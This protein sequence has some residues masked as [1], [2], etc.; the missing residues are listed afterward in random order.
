MA[1]VPDPEVVARVKLKWSDWV[2]IEMLSARWVD[3]NTG[4]VKRQKPRKA[5]D[6]TPPDPEN[7]GRYILADPHR[8][9]VRIITIGRSM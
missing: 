7:A 9:D 5:I 8:G 2:R 1:S 6:R 4:H 3:T